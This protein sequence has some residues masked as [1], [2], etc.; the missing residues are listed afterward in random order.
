MDSTWTGPIRLILLLLIFSKCYCL[1]WDVSNFPN[2]TAGDYKR[3]RMRTTSNICDPDEVLTEQ[4][5]YRLNHELHQLE[6][7]TRQAVKEMANQILRKWTLDKQCQ[8]SVVFVIATEDRRFWV[9]RDARVPVYAQEFTQM[10]NDQKPL[11]QQGD[12]PQALGNIIQ[13]TWEKAISKQGGG[14]KPSD[15]DDKDGS[16]PVAPPPPRVIPR[17]DDGKKS[18][19]LLPHIPFWFWI[20]LIFIVL[21][22]LCCCCCLCYCCCCR[23]SSGANAPRRQR[24]TDIE[25]G[26]RGPMDDGTGRPRSARGGG[27]N[28]NNILG[29]LGGAGLGHLAGQ[30]LGG[31]SKRRNVPASPGYQGGGAYPAAP[32]QPSRGYG[33]GTRGG[34]GATTG[35]K[36]LYPTAAVHDE[37]GGGGW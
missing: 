13:Q 37:G 6:S 25:G 5:R 22:V 14:E 27:F 2:P 8:K 30:L 33:D 7:R 31:G 24:P 32:Y 26:G 3:C 1:D 17:P 10:F 4:Q 9:A 29:G 28:F 12:Y 19:G 35:G 11:F 23:K 15:M 21:P 36:G 18:R 34:R 16:R 20:V